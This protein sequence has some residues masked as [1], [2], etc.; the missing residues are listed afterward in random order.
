M[1]KKIIC[2]GEP[3]VRLTSPYGKRLADSGQLEFHYGGSEMNVAISLAQM[4]LNSSFLTAIPDSAVGEGLL[5][6]LRKN[7]VD[8]S[9]LISNG[10]RFGLYFHEQGAA[11]RGAK[12]M[13]DRQFTAFSQVELSNF[14]IE[15]AFEEA[16]WLHLSGISPAVSKEAADCSLGLVHQ[17]KAKGLRISVDLNYRQNLWAYGIPPHQIMPEIV[18]HASVLLGDP[19]TINLMMG[20]SVPVSDRYRSGEEL[21]ESYEE[22]GSLYPNLDVIAMLMRQ[23]H[24]ANHHTVNGVLYK[25]GMINESRAMEISPIVERIGSGDAFMAG[26]IYGLIH[27]SVM[28]SVLDYAT[29]ACALKMT[30]LGDYSTFSAEEID[31]YRK[32]TK[33]G[34]ISR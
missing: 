8:T 13:Y 17:A 16:S 15:S 27:F 25:D 7:S 31:S 12:V 34:K 11:F 19:G 14:D 29:T 32:Q 30:S 4:G 3:L 10:G 18:K 28:K 6:T 33:N 20:T 1:N 22:L 24:S 9:D 5:N 23:V 21:L 26:L 2:F